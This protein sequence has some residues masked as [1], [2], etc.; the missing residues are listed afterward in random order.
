MITKYNFH[1]Y[2]FFCFLYKFQ[3]MFQAPLKKMKMFQRST[4][5]PVNPLSCGNARR[6]IHNI[7]VPYISAKFKPNN[8]FCIVINGIECWRIIPSGE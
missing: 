2:T 3:T 1:F 8:N 7:I 6:Q 5:D 4:R